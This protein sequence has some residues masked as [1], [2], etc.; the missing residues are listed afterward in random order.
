MT[1]VCGGSIALE[2]QIGAM[3]FVAD[4]A[5]GDLLSSF[6]AR[7]MPVIE[8]RHLAIIDELYKTRSVSQAAERLGVSQPTIS[9][10]LAKLRKHFGDPFFVRTSDGMVPT[11]LA[12]EVI[13]KLGQAYET[14]HEALEHHVAFDPKSSNRV[15]NVSAGDIIEAV[16]LP[17]LLKELQCSAPGIRLQ[18]WGVSREMARLLESGEVDVAVGMAHKLGAG[19]YQQKLYADRYVCL[20]RTEHPR[21]KNHVSLKQYQEENHVVVSIP[22]IGQGYFGTLLE[23]KNVERKIGVYLHNWLA[24]SYIV[25]NTDYLASVPERSGKVFAST[26]K[27]KLL[28]LPFEAPVAV[29][30]YWHQRYAHDAGSLWLRN[31]LKELFND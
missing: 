19:F 11:P 23:E 25:A 21:I 20:V 5:L 27:V 14:I 17:K 26:G 16:A 30:Q 15:F 28:S 8:L 3:T 12:L 18:F 24:L 29:K 2:R 22:G 10:S 7:N 4:G 9:V 6:E 1:L 13:K 31:T